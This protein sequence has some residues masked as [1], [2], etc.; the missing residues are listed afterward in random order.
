VG[1]NGSGKSRIFEIINNFLENTIY[2]YADSTEKVFFTNIPECKINKNNS[3][4]I[5]YDEDISYLLEEKIFFKQFNWKDK[6]SEADS[7]LAEALEKDNT[8]FNFINDKF[9]FKYWQVKKNEYSTIILNTKIKSIDEN[10]SVNKI[11]IMLGDEKNP[12]DFYLYMF[13]ITA[14]HLLQDTLKSENKDLSKSEYRE[15]L[16]KLGEELTEENYLSFVRKI[17][18]RKFT[19]GYKE[20]LDVLKN[21]E[22]SKLEIDS[23]LEKREINSSEIRDFIKS[24]IYKTFHN[25]FR[26]NSGIEFIRIDYQTEEGLRFGDLSDG[27]KA[28]I[29]NFSVFIDSLISDRD[30]Y[31]FIMCIDE[32]DAFLHPNWQ[33]SLINEFYKI[34]EKYA[35][36]KFK[37]LHIILSS[38]S[39]FILS[40]LPKENV[41]FL[42]KGKQVYP[43]ENN[44]QTFG[45]NI[46]TILSHGFFMKDGLM[47]EFA[48]DKI[49]IAIKYLNQTK[50][51]DDEIIYC[52][53]IIS[54]IG[55]PIIKRQLQK[56]L[57][58]KRL[59]KIDE[60]DKIYDEIEFLK[61]RVE[62][63]R[64]NQ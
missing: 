52:E 29:L 8:A 33:K 15:E 38:H 62:S 3:Y 55:E 12:K 48:K 9:I 26:N 18:L 16:E 22:Q 46:H 47:G 21:Y 28:K 10:L 34:S 49:D 37:N 57:D 58:S 39:P 31:N 44:Q 11:N 41:I 20:Y 27:E 6:D 30:H 1:E 17:D 56:M 60:I 14:I 19:K 5:E 13:T 23:Y 2:I 7:Y 54:I 64:K 36:D 25:F 63:L 43:F 24:P 4:T 42:E 61:H 40:D 32:P 59:K 35:K 50:L 45:A 53:N 51:S